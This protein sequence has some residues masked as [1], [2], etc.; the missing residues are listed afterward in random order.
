MADEDDI[1]PICRSSRYLSPE[2]KFLMNPECYHKM[3]ESCVDR[4]F[5]VGPAPCPYRGCGKIL[6]K[7]RFK[8]QV[9]DDLGVEREV[10]VRQRVCKI[11]NRREDSFESEEAY[12]NYLER[13]E[14][15]IY[16][17]VNGGP[18]AEKAETEV[19]E[20]EKQNKTE[21]LENALRQRQEDQYDEEMVRQE[22]ERQRRLRLLA[23][24]LYQQEEEVKKQMEQETIRLLAAGSENPEAVVAKTVE[25]G[26]IRAQQLRE[27]YSLEANR[28]IYVQRKQT[29]YGVRQPETPFTPFAGDRQP[30]VQF[31]VGHYYDPVM[32]RSTDPLLRASGFNGKRAHNQLLKLTFMN[33]NIDTQIEKLQKEP[34]TDLQKS[35]VVTAES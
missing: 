20:Y 7:S 24:E 34:T 8:E 27:Q 35:F 11:F 9:F 19:S 33:L 23:I 28:R 6:R 12:N 17:I 14:N 32:K 31:S 21:I 2:M 22:T 13:I 25:Q 30:Y 3:C 5:S 10:D 16:S 26:R 1:C 18:E 29:S 15:L 4:I